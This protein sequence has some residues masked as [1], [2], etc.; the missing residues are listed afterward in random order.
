MSSLFLP[1]RLA[2]LRLIIISF[3]A[4]VMFA[5][6]QE[7]PRKPDK[8]V[9][10]LKEP[11]IKA[12]K[13]VVRAENEQIEDFLRR[14]KWDMTETGSGLR[15]MIYHHGKGPAS[16]RGSVA[17]LAYSVT[18]LTGDT[19]YTSREKGNLEFVPGNA[20][21]ISGLEE[22]ILLLREGDRAKFIIPSHLAFG[23]IGDQDRI[24]QKATLVYD[25][26]LLKIKK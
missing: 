25:V 11:L 4:V 1:I 15:Y 7:V 21:V 17:E 8:P 26:E 9:T 22:G 3:P 24:G 16:E 13:E 19:V 10:E 2:L 18:F 6:T 20:Q 5:C 23:L 12:N 14:Y